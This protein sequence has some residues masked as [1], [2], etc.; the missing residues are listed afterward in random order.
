MDRS[1][2]RSVVFR[3]TAARSATGS[4]PGRSGWAGFRTAATRSVICFC[5]SGVFRS[6]ERGSRSNSLM[7][8]S[9]TSAAFRS[10]GRSNRVGVG[11]P[12][13]PDGG[14]PVPA[15]RFPIVVGTTTTCVRLSGMSRPITT[16]LRMIEFGLFASSTIS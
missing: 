5:T 11:F 13:G 8:S 1:T 12:A 6:A 4:T 15:I 2:N 9:A 3:T 7:T 14:V 10:S 16:P